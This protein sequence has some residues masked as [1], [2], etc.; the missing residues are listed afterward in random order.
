M[1]CWLC[2]GKLKINVGRTMKVD[3]CLAPVKDICSKWIKDLN[4]RVSDT[5]KL[6]GEAP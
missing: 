2:K 3:P 5:V 4:V 1:M 6:P